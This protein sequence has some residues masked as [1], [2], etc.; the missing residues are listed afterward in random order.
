MNHEQESVIKDIKQ[1]IRELG[2]SIIC[3]QGGTEAN[4]SACVSA[5]A[6]LGIDYPEPNTDATDWLQIQCEDIDTMIMDINS[7][8]MNHDILLMYHPDDPGTMIMI[9]MNDA[10]WHEG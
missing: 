7:V 1:D 4:Y 8:L 10:E 3:D 2:G 5:C 6:L 9:D